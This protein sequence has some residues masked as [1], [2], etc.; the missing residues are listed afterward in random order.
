MPVFTYVASD[1][2]GK[3][4]KGSREAVTEEALRFALLAQNLDVESIAE[5]RPFFSMS[6]EL[7]R[8]RVKPQEIMHF[9]RQLAAFVRSGIAITDALQV[10]EEGTENKAWRKV[11]GRIRE[12][13]EAGVPF[14]DA[15]GEHSSLFP[16]YY[17]GILRSS[18]LTGRLDTALDQLASYMDRDIEARHK[19]KSALT[20]PIVVATMSVATVVILATF[21]LPKFVKFFKSFHSKLPLP[22]RMLIGIANFFKYYWWVTPATVVLILGTVYWLR[23]TDHGRHVRDRVMLH[24]PLVGAIVNDAVVER[25]SRIMGAMVAAGVPLPDAMAASIAAANNSVYGAKLL[26]AQERMLEGEGLAEPVADTGIFPIAAVQMMRVGENT[27]TLELQLANV[28]DYYGRELEFKLKK[29]T[30]LFEPMVILFMGVVV[31]FV[32]VALISA[33]YGVLQGQKLPK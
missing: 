13:I 1:E 25:F 2:V 10:V 5:K 11:V 9:S 8:G 12:N 7:G 31:G 15:V 23:K 27:G 17:L 6:F 3:K 4:V 24:I 14:S 18:E 28:S 26:A 16:P 21:V 29:L 22:T 33:M 30:S 19:V 20:Y 32:A